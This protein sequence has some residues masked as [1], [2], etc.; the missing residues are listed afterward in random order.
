ML[1][2]VRAEGG[3]MLPMT[4]GLL[5]V[6]LVI[7][8]LVIEIALLGAAYRDVAT[9]ADLAAESAA[10]RVVTENVYSGEIELD[11]TGAA[12]EARRVAQMWGSGNE[13][14]AIDVSGEQVCVTIED[15]YKPRTLMFIG[16]DTVTVRARSCASPR[17]G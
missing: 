10:S 16:V 6:G 12:S 11:D 8:A 3:S 5:F 1:Y 9:V 14:V 7:T 15:T 2:R 13:T 4:G 17:S